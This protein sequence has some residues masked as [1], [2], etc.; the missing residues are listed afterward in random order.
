MKIFN[1]QTKVLA[2]HKS[3]NKASLKKK[4]VSGGV[5][6]CLKKGRLGTFFFIFGFFLFSKKW[7]I[8]SYP[9]KKIAASRLAILT[10]TCWT[11]NRF[12]FVDSLMRIPC[13]VATGQYKRGTVKTFDEKKL[14]VCPYINHLMTRTLCYGPIQK[15]TVQ[16][17]KGQN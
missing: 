17:S 1:R 11:G 10:A 16:T 7:T 3:L 13:Y 9:K 14:S 6:G 5:A 15:I 12:L 8:F 4:S 2:I